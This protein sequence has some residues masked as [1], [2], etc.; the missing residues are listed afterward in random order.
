MSDIEFD[1]NAGDL[2]D[3]NE[4]DAWWPRS[5]Q[6]SRYPGAHQTRDEYFM[7][8]FAGITVEADDVIIDLNGFEIRQSLPFYYQQRFFSCIALKSVAFNLNEGPGIFGTDPR[9]SSNVLIK[10]G[11]IGLSSH[12]GIHGQNNR[13]VTI[14]NVHV[15]SFETHG[16]EM[17]YFNDLTLKQVEIGP[18]SDVAYLKGEYAYARFTLQRL[19]RIQNEGNVDLNEDVFPIEF[20]G[21]EETMEFDDVIQNLRHLMDIAFKS[22]MKIQEYDANDEDYIAA[23][24][25]FINSD[26]VPYGAVMYGLFLNLRVANVFQIHPSMQHSH[27][28]IIH[29]LKIHDLHHKTMEY[30]RLDK[31]MTAPYKNP[32]NAALDATSVLGD[33]IKHGADDMDWST[34][35]YYAVTF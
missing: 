26:G 11:Q 1:F 30:L 23:K 28:A 29:D 21:R 35:N 18:S 6:S 25:L 34:E 12:H 5:S 4:G 20:D 19:E 8:F 2:N 22:V 24:S 32:Y 13:G 27:N 14:E 7:G 3:P 17:T 10:N 15:H 33:Q 9:F 31:F 16:I